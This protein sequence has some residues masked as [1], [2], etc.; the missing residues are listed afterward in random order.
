MGSALERI[1]P[2]LS[3]YNAALD[4]LGEQAFFKKNLEQLFAD[5]KFD[6]SRPPFAL[7]ESPR[8]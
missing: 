2:I 3:D 4:R 8:N 7:G 5:Y 1:D 6:E